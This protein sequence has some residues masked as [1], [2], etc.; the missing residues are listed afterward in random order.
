MAFTVVHL[1]RLYAPHVGGVEKHVE[2]LTAELQKQDI[3][4]SIITTTHTA[5]LAEKEDRSGISVFRL[6][7]SSEPPHG[8]IT[9]LHYKLKTWQ[10]IWKHKK[11]LQSAD[12]IHIH[13]VFWWLLPLLPFLSRKKLFMTFH[14]YEG[15][16]APTP[17]KILSHQLAAWYTQAN[18]C[19]GDFHA[20][21]YHLQPTAVT[22]GA[23]EIPQKMK[24]PAKISELTKLI[25]I[26]RLSLDSGIK[27]YLAAVAVL[28]Q[29]G[30]PV[31]LDVYG[32]GPQ[33]AELETYVHKQ[34]LP[35]Q[36]FGAVLDAADTIPHYH[37]ACVSR[38]L[39][40][41]EAIAAGIPIVAEYSTDIKYDYLRLA[42]YADAIHIVRTPQEIA[43]SIEEIR[44]KPA[45]RSY[46][47]HIQNWIQAQS[48]QQMATTYRSLWNLV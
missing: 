37:I 40:I 5:D 18:L 10:A 11:L 12:V 3:A 24:Y 2:M 9:G 7:V 21:W 32:D 15:N 28:K 26:G 48:W 19:V 47:K 13:D 36:F 23:V 22:Y 43:D 6:P 16:E 29:R 39:A 25:Y 44:T 20:P 46:S 38:Y 4:N 27:S 14:G 31:R 33:R 45:A 35:V 41:L 8:F 42:P 30:I 17:K 34:K 1:C